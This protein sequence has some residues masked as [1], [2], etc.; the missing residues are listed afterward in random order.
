MKSLT[1][2]VYLTV[3]AVKIL[4]QRFSLSHRA[5]ENVLPVILFCF[6]MCDACYVAFESPRGIKLLSQAL[7]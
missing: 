3:T 5:L 1:D 4:R 2:V 7:E 6:H